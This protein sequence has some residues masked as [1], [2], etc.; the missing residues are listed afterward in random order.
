MSEAAATNRSPGSRLQ[1]WKHYDFGACIPYYDEELDLM[2]SKAHLAAVNFLL[3]IFSYIA[4][5]LGLACLSDNPIWYIDPATEHQ[6]AFA[7][8]LVFARPGEIDRETAEDLALVMEIVSTN[9]PRKEKKDTIFHKSLNE[10]NQVP[11][12][13]LYFPDQDDKRSIEWYRLIEN[14]YRQITPDQDGR[15]TS[16]AVPGLTLQVLPPD[17]WAD[18]HKVRVLFDGQEILDFASEHEARLREREARLKAEE[19]LRQLRAKP[20]EGS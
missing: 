1:R 6:K 10:F 9:D 11:E 4:R 12:F 3:P 20:G 2:H 14:R 5:L 16:V 8:D 17:A 18:G 15:L 7:G 19:E 13:V